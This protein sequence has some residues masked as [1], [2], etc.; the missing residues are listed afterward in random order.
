MSVLVTGGAGYIGSHMVLDLLDAG[1]RVIALDD[2][3]SGFAWAVAEDA[4]LIVGNAGDRELVAQVLADHNVEAIIHLA[5]SIVVPESIK[6]P[7]GY[8]ENNTVA[9]LSL[10][11]CAVRANVRN[12]IFSSSAAVYGFPAHNPVS[13]GAELRPIS[14]Y[15][16]SKMMS[17]IMLRD[18]A[19]AH[20]LRY[21]ALRYFNVAGAD[22]K[23]RA[24][25]S[26]EGAT[27]LIK[28]ACEVAL[29]KR[30]HMK[31]F[32]TDYATPDGTCLRDYIH[33][34]DL[35]AAHRAALAYLRDGGASQVLNCGYGSAFSVLEVIRAVERA[36]GHPIDARPG[37]RRPGDSP[38]LMADASRIR[39]LLNWSPEHCDLDTI[40]RTALAWEQGTS[41]RTVDGLSRSPEIRAK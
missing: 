36:A 4:P 25:Q 24:G 27:H 21:V 16:S 2:L 3:S 20:D 34:T 40:V 18:A 1:E 22:P 39:E 31:I 9:T 13:E 26:S 38:S 17:E 11:E 29:G 10:I 5:G 35:A 28:V 37:Q 32:G 12:F 33:V 7:L 8:Y 30:P 19:A 15:G 14:P 41:E 23:G 6:D